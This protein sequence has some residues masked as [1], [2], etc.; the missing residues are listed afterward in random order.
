M[1]KKSNHEVSFISSSMSKSYSGWIFQTHV[2]LSCAGSWMW[3]SCITPKPSK[4]SS[5][6][7]E[8]MYALWFPR[9]YFVCHA[10]IGTWTI[11]PIPGHWGA[12]HNSVH[13]C[14][15]T[16]TALAAMISSFWRIKAHK[17]LHS[18]SVIMLACLMSNWITCLL[19][20][21]W[22]KLM[23]TSDSSFA[24]NS[25]CRSFYMADYR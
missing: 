19:L 24:C 14:S 15:L 16:H 9:P 8:R 25:T 21:E 13:L 12:L 2:W 4:Y 1:V 17:S 23:T 10:R 11:A 18:T 20:D 22:N 3:S 7:M 5:G 6:A